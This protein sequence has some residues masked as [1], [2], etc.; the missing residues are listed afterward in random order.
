MPMDSL[1]HLLPFVSI[2]DTIQSAMLL[3]QKL[4]N[5]SSDLA[6]I[7][8]TPYAAVPVLGFVCFRAAIAFP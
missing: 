1:K 6:S 5:S 4:N 3:N 7:P 8:C 2:H